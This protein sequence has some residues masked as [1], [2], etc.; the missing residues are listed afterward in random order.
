MN[1]KEKGENIYEMMNAWLRYP[2]HYEKG[3]KGYAWR[4]VEQFLIV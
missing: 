3:N 1:T 2:Y 4:I